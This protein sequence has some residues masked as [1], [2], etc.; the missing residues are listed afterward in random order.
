M[1]YLHAQCIEQF[2]HYADKS[3]CTIIF[4]NQKFLDILFFI[5]GQEFSR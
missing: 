2:H 1:N 5:V 4:N 3:Y